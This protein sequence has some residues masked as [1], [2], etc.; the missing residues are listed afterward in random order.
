MAY[1]AKELAVEY[2]ETLAFFYDGI[3][4]NIYGD[5]LDLIKATNKRLYYNI[6]NTINTISYLKHKYN[7]RLNKRARLKH[8]KD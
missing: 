6:N 3:T 4:K 5:I 2:D 1:L 8:G 7:G